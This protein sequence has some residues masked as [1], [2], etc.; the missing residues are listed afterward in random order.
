MISDTCNEKKD[1]FMIGEGSYKI[2][3]RDVSKIL[4]LPR[5]EGPYDTKPMEDKTAE[6]L[7]GS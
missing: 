3:S 5:K 2:S 7:F 1:T 4:R 6:T